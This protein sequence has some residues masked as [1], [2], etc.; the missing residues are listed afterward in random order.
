MTEACFHGSRHIT[1]GCP[2]KNKRG[3]SLCRPLGHSVVTTGS[4]TCLYPTKGLVLLHA[5]RGV[6]ISILAGWLGPSQSI[7][8]WP[9]IWSADAVAYSSVG[10]RRSRT[11]KLEHALATRFTHLCYLG[12][13][14]MYRWEQ[15]W[16]R[17]I[18]DLR[19]F[20]VRGGPV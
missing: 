20:T 1:G 5:Q 3:D 19:L 18:E 4:C 8:P 13:H 2:Q 6:C 15:A 10:S 11:Y 16:R 7:S 14:V 12:G 9:C 17:L